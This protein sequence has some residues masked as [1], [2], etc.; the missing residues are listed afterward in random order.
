M[1]QTNIDVQHTQCKNESATFETT[2]PWLH[3]AHRLIKATYFCHTLCQPATTHNKLVSAAHSDT[4]CCHVGIST[5]STASVRTLAACGWSVTSRAC[6][7]PLKA[8]GPQRWSRSSSL[9]TFSSFDTCLCTRAHKNM[10]DV[11]QKCF[12]YP[13]PKRC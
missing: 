8:F 1:L 6:T 7:K 5:C 11:T 10:V 3:S 13:S 12:Q 2:V 9:P 4:G